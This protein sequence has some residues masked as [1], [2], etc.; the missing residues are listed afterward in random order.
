M[1]PKNSQYISNRFVNI[2]AISTK[3]KQNVRYF[4]DDMID[5]NVSHFDLNRTEVCILN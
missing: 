2:E 1:N 5:T 3:P 4:A